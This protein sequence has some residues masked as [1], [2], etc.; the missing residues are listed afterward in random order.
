[1]RHRGLHRRRTAAELDCSVLNTILCMT[2]APDELGDRAQAAGVELTVDPRDPD[3][4]WAVYVCVH[5]AIHRGS[6]VAATLTQMLDC[7]HRRS[8]EALERD[9][10]EALAA[11]LFHG[12][13]RRVPDLAGRLWALGSAPSDEA[14]ELARWLNARV[15]VL[16]VQDVA[17]GPARQE[18]V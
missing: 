11:P 4:A 12:D 17:R 14:A 18:E 16:A 10:H 3:A 8:L 15:G 13:P 6:P 5:H 2:F 1:M 7:V 9:G